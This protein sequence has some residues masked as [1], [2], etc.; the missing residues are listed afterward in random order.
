M[1]DWEDRLARWQ[2]GGL[3]DAATVDRIRAFE[4]ARADD[5]PRSRWPA[6]ML[7]ALGGVL[8]G[9]GVLL[10]VAAHW[11]ELGPDTRF[12][13]VLAMVGGFHLGAVAAA[14]AYPVLATVLHAVGT[15]TLG[16]G[17]FLA[18]QIFNLQ[19]HWPG[20]ILLWAIGAAIGWAVLRDGPQ[21][22][23]LALLAPAWLVA[24]WILAVGDHAGDALWRPAGTGLLVLAAVYASAAPHGTRDPARRT[25][26]RIGSSALLP[27]ATAVIFGSEGWSYDSIWIAGGPV[28]AMGWTVALGVPLVLAVLLRRA[29][30]WIDVV[31]A[32][33]ALALGS[34]WMHHRELGGY[35]LCG[36]GAVGMT[37]WGL[38]ERDAARVNVGVA[39]FAAT[40]LVFYFSSVMDKLDRSLSLIGLGVLFIGGGWALE[41][42]RRTLLA[43]MEA[44]QP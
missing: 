13:L 42:A 3:I 44:S 10:F 1:A 18:G 11:E 35:F 40:V 28:R 30:A 24:E 8:L 34:P 41:R 43:R 33:W 36:L 38:H 23:L 2:G 27:A 6:A 20:G 7:W 39:G 16:G 9:A 4:A 37:W 12:G 14:V 29:D 17:I 32:L 22:G 19:E 31:V 26:A 5:S 25:L 15:T 21:A